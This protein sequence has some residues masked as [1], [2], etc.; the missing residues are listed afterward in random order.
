MEEQLLFD[1]AKEW[2][3]QNGVLKSF[4]SDSQLTFKVE[5]TRNNVVTT[6]E[7]EDLKKLTIEL[8]NSVAD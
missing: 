6:L 5:F 4:Y 2:L 3:T 1:N 7:G 8:Y